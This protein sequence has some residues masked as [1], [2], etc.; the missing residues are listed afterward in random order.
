MQ[1][2]WTHSCS[3]DWWLF[4]GSSEDL[5]Q[6]LL[7]LLA[8]SLCEWLRCRFWQIMMTS[9]CPHA[10]LRS[11]YKTI[12]SGKVLSRFG[13]YRTSDL[14]SKTNDELFQSPAF[15][16]CEWWEP[17]TAHVKISALA[18]CKQAQTQAEADSDFLHSELK[19][20]LMPSWLK[21]ITVF[22]LEPAA[23][24]K[25]DSRK[26]SLPV[27]SLSY[28]SILAVIKLLDFTRNYRGSKSRSP[29]DADNFQDL[30]VGSSSVSPNLYPTRFRPGIL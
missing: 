20:Y 14:T 2:R 16:I 8:C 30:N 1:N 24:D 11:T 28:L 10:T 19:P 29:W 7:R 15:L 5:S 18:C 9:Q 13:P 26:R 17:N 3:F 21:R 22:C 25:L 27:G 4:R 12:S 6:L 23:C